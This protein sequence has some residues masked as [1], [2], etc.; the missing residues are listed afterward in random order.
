MIASEV[1]TRSTPNSATVQG[2][3]CPRISAVKLAE[4]R[5]VGVAL[6][7]LTQVTMRRGGCT[8]G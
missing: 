1:G 4:R 6:A 2:T 8:H 7:T 3:S 5:E